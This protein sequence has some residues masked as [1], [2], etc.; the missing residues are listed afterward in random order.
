MVFTIAEIASA[1]EGDLDN[2]L[3]LIDAAATAKADAVK[4]QIYQADSL[5][6]PKHTYYQLYHKLQYSP[7]Q[8]EQIVTHA[9][10]SH[11]RVLADIF[12]SWGLEIMESCGADGYKI[13]PT[14]IW[15]DEL[16]ASVAVTSKPIYVGVGGIP[17]DDI[18]KA[19]DRLHKVNRTVT[20]VHGFQ[21]YPTRI[22]DTNLRRM[23]ALKQRFGVPVGFADHIDG[24]SKWAITLPL[25]AVGAGAAAI[26]K[27]LTLDR[28]A[29][30]LDHYSSLNP[31]EF[32]AMVSQIRE[33]ELAMGDEKVMAESEVN[34]IENVARR[35]VA[36][37]PV[38]AG[39][40]ITQNKITF[41][42]LP[43]KNGI[44]PKDRKQVLYQM[45]K[46]NIEANEPVSPDNVQPSRVGV[47]VAVR[48]KSTRLP[49]KAL[50][51]I[52]G[53][54]IIGHLFERVLTAKVPSVVV[55]CTSTHP[56]D[57][58]LQGEAKKAGVKF[59]AGSEDDVMERFLGAARQENVDIIVR[60]TGDCPFI[61]PEYID[62]AI[63]FLMDEKADY[64]RIVGMPLGV[65]CE[66]F[67]TKA[68]ELAHSRALDPKYSEYM[69]FYFWNNPDVFRIRE[70][71][72]EEAVKRPT[73]RL[74]IDESAD[75]DL[76]KEIYGRLY[77]GGRVFPMKELIQML[78][79][80]PDLL[81]MNQGAK[82]KWRDN[83]EFVDLLNEKTKLRHA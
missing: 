54:T 46:K 25:I 45:A 16:L 81:A 74:T 76:F 50:L 52:E 58:I 33:I 75:Y 21:S 2:M 79:S 61:D 29:K 39:E 82:V 1:H 43:D 47:L 31:D 69:S 66:V 30:G 51:E 57:A 20:L 28:A 3:K 64:A 8:W 36:S 24:D 26:E 71:Q 40:W 9:H 77:N 59:F 32:A 42:R 19:L 60:V 12:D 41:K 10:G 4:F 48:M 23:L 83:K 35:I 68:L 14:V 22:E 37:R 18:Q 65:G 7:R 62:K 56:D 38:A 11:L 73:Y 6:V 5:A 49:R 80:N 72:C 27:H 70:L 17:V 67:T 63:K 34:Y 55:L 53:K 78:D 15:E 44:L 13:H